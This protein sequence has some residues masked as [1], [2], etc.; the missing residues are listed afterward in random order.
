MSV[1]YLMRFTENF[2]S[3]GASRPSFASE[4][5]TA[6]ARA[7]DLEPSQDVE[8]DD[9]WLTVSTEKF[10]SVLQ[11]KMGLNN[12]PSTNRK[13]D[14]DQSPDSENGEDDITKAQVAKL[15]DLANKVDAFVTGEGDVEGAMFEE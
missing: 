9:D 2:A 13:M 5:N 10:D 14:I 6:I 7:N 8:D 4:V 15:R 11:E 1:R 3:S 12:A